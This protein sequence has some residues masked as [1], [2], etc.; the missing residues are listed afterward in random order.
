VFKADRVRF[1]NLV[2]A[3]R[4]GQVAGTHKQWLAYVLAVV[5]SV[6]ML[7]L[8]QQM[9]EPF[10]N[11]PLLILFMLPIIL[12]AMIGG[13]GSGLLATAIVALGVNYLAMAPI[14]SLKIDASPDIF[15]WLVLI[16]NGVLVSVLAGVLRRAQRH[17]SHELERHRQ[18]SQ[19]LVDER[20]RDLVAA[21]D[22]LADRERFI[23]T[24]TDAV[25]GM[26]GY[27]SADLRC[28][29]GNAAYRQWFGRTSE[30]MFGVPMQDLLGEA[31]FERNEPYIRGAQRGEV[32]RFQRT[33]VRTDGTT[34]YTLASYIPD[35][36]GGEV[37]G[38]TAVVTD[39]SDVK[40][41]ELQLADLNEQLTRR[42][43]EA[44]AATQAKSAFL[45]NM[46]HEIRTPMNAIIGLNYLLARDSTDALQ[47]ERLGKV[48][49][50]AR[51]LLQVINDILDLSKIEAGK[52]GLEQRQFA[53]DEVLERVTAMVRTRAAEKGLEL[54]VDS[55][56]LPAHLI[57]D[58]TRLSQLLIN[59]L[60][61]AVKF[62]ATGW[63]RLRGSLLSCGAEGLLLRFEVQDTGPGVPDDQQARLFEAFEQGDS[64]TTRQHGG[65]G[66][67]LALTRRF[68]ALMG[69]ECGMVSR[70]GEGSTFWFTVRLQVATEVPV[71]RP[72][73][74]FGG[75]TALLVDD[76]AEA[77][78]A[79]GDRL[80]QFGL[81]VEERSDGAGA[82]QLLQDKAQAGRAFDVLLVDWQ[83]PG[84]DGLEFLRQARQA[85]AQNLPP[86]VLITAHDDQDLWLRARQAGVADVLLKPVTAST[87]QEGLA[88][89]LRRP[90]PDEAAPPP[91][92]AQ[93]ARQLR[94]RCAGQRVLLAEDNPINREVAV[95]LLESAGLSVDIA[96]DGRQAVEL[97]LARDYALILMDMQ[98]PI[99]D[100]LDATRQIRACL[101]PAMPILAMTANA[102]HEN[103]RACL[104][105]GMNDHLSKPVD[106]DLL[107]RRLLHWLPS[108]QGAAA[109]QP[110]ATAE[111]PERAAPPLPAKPAETAPP[112]DPVALTERP[113]AQRLADM[114]GYNYAHGLATIGGD[115]NKLVKI[116]RTFIGRYSSGDAILLEAAE[117]GD[118]RAIQRASH[119]IRSACGSI[120]ALA[121]AELAR[122]LETSAA[123][124]PGDAESLRAD[125]QQLGAQLADVAQAIAR[126]LGV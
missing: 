3:L 4:T 126:E 116:L 40:R 114:P 89:A 104:D 125:A 22:A 120:G 66:L 90:G 105:A 51:H 75:L 103:Q 17:I 71:T 10:G 74:S 82:L 111:L 2:A 94:E 9:A 96:T 110:A 70:V 84:M 56:H 32:Q 15:Q 119:S 77:R 28:R 60:S 45:A 85:H 124:E 13:A 98:M 63:V 109:A 23:R 99:L 37:H 58:P 16:V 41:A 73:H 18:D 1:I 101:G 81:N 76:L 61:N 5:L 38:F 39:I 92:S 49:D 43:A 35:V 79:I 122:A 72:E 34:G 27:W 93:A 44:E 86:A 31:L 26:V 33:L 87:L 12:S 59:L 36:V 25:P 21:R 11:R 14:G 102:F 115:P 57:G 100:G 62:T 113:L 108:A 107:F 112:A 50:A 91:S 65:T 67:G 6:A 42:A 55:D 46:S 117:Q 24:I 80:R 19:L 83:M 52:M 53:L 95:D 88:K 121:V 30:Q 8:R 64:S 48:D 7:L 20:T 78:E 69:G 29:F 54:I 118:C 97:A 106:P 68:A 123:A 47:R